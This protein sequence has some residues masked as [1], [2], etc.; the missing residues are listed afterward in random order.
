M[1]I[2][3][4][5]RDQD[6]LGGKVD[7]ENHHFKN[8][9]LGKR[10][11]IVSVL[12]IIVGEVLITLPLNLFKFSSSLWVNMFL[13]AFLL[14]ILLFPAIYYWGIR[15]LTIQIAERE[16]AEEAMNNSLSLMDAILESI[17]NGILVVSDQTAVLKTNAKF[18][19]LW[20]IPDDIL[21]SRDD[22]MLMDDVLGQLS[23]PDA[24]NATVL[25]LYEKP[26][27]E[28]LD[29]IY[30]KDGRIFKRISKPIYLNGE[31]KGRVWSFLDIT[32]RKRAEKALMVS[33]EKYRYMF[34]NNPQPM[35]IF[36]LETLAFL[37]VNQAAVNHYG[38][39]TEEFLTMTIKNIRPPEDL[40]ALYEDIKRS[41]QINNSGTV[42]RHRKKNGEIIFVEI[43]SHFVSYHGK[44]ARHVLV[45]DVTDRKW[46]EAEIKSKNEQLLKSLAEKNRFF[47]IIAHDLKSPFN[48]FLGLTQTMAERLPSLTIEEL[49]Q[50]A[51][52]MENSATNLYG[53]LNNLLQW[54]S[55]EQ[56]LIPFNPEILKLLPI[57]EESLTTILDSAKNKEIE[58]TIDISE[59]TAVLTDKNML[60]TILRNFVSNAV[61][62]TPKRGKINVSAK[63]IDDK[64]VE[65]A[66]TDSGIGMSHEM[67]DN[68]F[69]PDVQMNRKGTE[70][71]PSTGLGLLLC[72]EFI[73]KQD[74]KIWVESKEGKGSTFY[75]TLPFHAEMEE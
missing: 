48:G 65:I 72:K 35:W 10:L 19:E 47:S 56:G 31:P 40:P 60:Q 33:E 1:K 62:F 37:E 5:P 43:S 57:A 41:S 18:A 61:K 75:F 74:G 11:A 16:K 4:Q 58:I 46:A 26:K 63:T 69:R 29:T 3:E 30:L 71:E 68:L 66:I 53:L 25:E 13:D 2:Q 44:E 36:D 22:K 21:A 34:A 28:S 38:Y 45:H 9:L 23:D 7:K 24:F 39:S 32:E 20:H 15:P 59:E 55:V 6:T 14:A 67:V 42:W 52:V 73:E 54:A 8:S 12:S 51:L 49:Q 27:A 50:I 64:I 17:H 70:G